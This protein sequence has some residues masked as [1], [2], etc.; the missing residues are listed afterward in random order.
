LD[1][2]LNTPEIGGQT[3]H[4]YFGDRGSAT[5]A[6]FA[7]LDTDVTTGYGPETVTIYEMYPGVY[8]Y[9]VYNY[10]QS[11]EITTSNAVVQIY[12]VNGLQH[13]LQIPNSGTG[14]YWY[15]CDV[16][17][18]TGAITIR[19]VIQENAPGGQRHDMPEKPSSSLKLASSAILCRG[20]G[21]LVMVQ[22]VPNK[23]PQ[24]PI[25]QTALTL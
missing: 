23:T 25:L 15:V 18:S 6:P 17:G 10:S 2:H 22:L 9:Y 4:I 5:E 1:S 7:L 20:V 12:N 13:T 3:Y 19:N 14:L 8:Q 24:K 21:L 11:P 16:N